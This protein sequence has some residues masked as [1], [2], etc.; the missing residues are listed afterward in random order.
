M[1]LLVKC[2][3]EWANHERVITNMLEKAVVDGIKVIILGSADN[4]DTIVSKAATKM[5]FVVIFENADRIRH[6]SSAGS[7]RD[8][9]MLDRLLKF[10]IRRASVL[11]DNYTKS[12]DVKNIVKHL[13]CAGVNVSIYTYNGMEAKF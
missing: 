9:A 4:I 7:I 6:G 11:H 1:A 3:S 13:K 12:T 2:D 10:D 8:K 5:G